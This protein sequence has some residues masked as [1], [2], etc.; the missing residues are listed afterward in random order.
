MQRCRPYA[1]F[2]RRQ[3]Q[4]SVLTNIRTHIRSVSLAA[5]LLAGTFAHS[6]VQAQ[7]I[8]VQLRVITPHI[9]L[10][11]HVVLPLPP[12]IVPRV[13][14]SQPEPVWQAPPR[15]D[16]GY[17]EPA[18][19]AHVYVEPAR[20]T[21]VYVEPARRDYGY[22]EPKRW[23]VDGDGIPNRHDPVYNPRW[24]RDGDGVPNRYDPT[25][26]GHRG[27]QGQPTW[28]DDR[29]GE[30]RDDRRADRR[31]DRHDDHRRGRHD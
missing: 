20:P 22:R 15:Q 8:N 21:Y 31:D 2:N 13:V 14:V 27:W 11:G 9:R 6:A 17:R 29:R 7:D 16:Y 26:Q 24:D 4:E 23:D 10:P 25:P 30:W 12:L 5:T 19:P 1:P 18:R 3:N 28:R